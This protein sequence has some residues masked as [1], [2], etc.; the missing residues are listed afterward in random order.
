M[1]GNIIIFYKTVLLRGM[2]L[3]Y[4][5]QSLGMSFFFNIFDSVM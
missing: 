2:C 1:Q 4:S 5:Y 3:F